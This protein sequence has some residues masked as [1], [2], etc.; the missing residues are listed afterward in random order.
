[1]LSS[2]E[3]RDLVHRLNRST[4]SDA[5]EYLFKHAILRDVAYETVLLRI[6]KKYHRL[7]ALWLQKHSGERV[8]EFASLIADHYESGEDWQNAATWLIRSGRSAMETSAYIEAISRFR[9]ALAVPEEIIDHTV[10]SQLHLD[11]GSCLEKLCRYPEAKAEVNEALAMAEENGDTGIA[12]ESLLVLAWIAILTGEPGRAEEFS[13]RAFKKAKASEDSAILARAYMRMADFEEDKTYEKIIPYYRKAHSIY[14]ELNS[15]SGLAI[16][17]LNM[18]N[19]ALTFDRLDE[20]EDFYLKSLSL[21]R[22]LGNRWGIANCLGN[23]GCVTSAGKEFG[24]ACEYYRKSLDVSIRIGDREGEA[25]CY[26]NL[27]QS[28]INLGE[29][30][31]ALEY[32]LTSLEVSSSVGLIP[33]SVGALKFMSEA[34]S[35][36]EEKEKAVLILLVLKNN[37]AFPENEKE[38]LNRSLAELKSSFSSEKFKHII[39]QADSMD[40]SSIVTYLIKDE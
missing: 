6:R 22:K 26:L 5:G 15:E 28:F 36:Q 38:K 7:V 21:Y 40:V 29:P 34:Y 16:T 17:L 3:H 31:K 37:D 20:A 13:H 4:F 39:R 35:K 27:G 2:V 12:A 8:S 30:Q 25:I 14:T 24:K 1:M 10:R 33:L 11:C 23:L 18:G 19:V 9:R 32:L